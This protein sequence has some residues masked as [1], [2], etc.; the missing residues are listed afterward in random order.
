M[1]QLVSVTY[2][3][4]CTHRVISQIC[5]GDVLHLRVLGPVCRMENS[6][7][8]LKKSVRGKQF[9]VQAI[10]FTHQKFLNC[11]QTSKKPS[12]SFGR[13]QCFVRWQNL[14]ILDSILYQVILYNKHFWSHKTFCGS[15]VQAWFQ[16]WTN[17]KIFEFFANAKVFFLSQCKQ[18]LILEALVPG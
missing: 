11:H 5:H 6:V 7:C 9:L 2:R 1:V 8:S 16:K 10:F 17:Y 4:T 12:I 3:L 18:G 13:L 15:Q 14:L